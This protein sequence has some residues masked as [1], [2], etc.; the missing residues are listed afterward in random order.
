MEPVRFLGLSPLSWV[1]AIPA[2]TTLGILFTPSAAKNAVRRIALAGMTLTFGI[3]IWILV[4]AAGDVGLDASARVLP[5]LAQKVEWVRE[6]G[7]S[8]NVG[9]DGMGAAMVF[10]TSIV[11]FAGVLVSWSV[12]D[13]TKEFYLSLIALVTGVFGVFVSRDLFWFYFSY[14]LAVIPMYL[15]IGI[16]GS[17]NKE[18]ASM[19]LTLYLTTGAVCALVGLLM[20]YFRAWAFLKTP[21][22]SFDLDYILM[23]RDA[24][25]FDATWRGMDF[26]VFAFPFLL[27][28]FGAIAPMWPLHTWSPMGH[29]AAPSAASMLHAGVLMKLGSFAILRIAVPALPEG[30]VWWMPVVAVLCMFNILYG[31]L[32][33]IAQKDMKFI[34]GYSSSSHMGYVLLGI[35]SMTSLGING[36]IFLMF[37]HGVM[38]AL[39][40]ALIGFFYDQTHVRTIPDLGGMSHQIP[41]IGTAF[42][43]MSMASAGVPGFANF[44]S[45]VM[46]M[47]GAWQG[48]LKWQAVVAV[49]GI[50]PTGV[51]LLRAV[52]GAFFGPRNPRW[53][54]LRDAVTPFQRLPFLFLIS[55]LLLF[56]FWPRLLTDVIGESA[57][58]LAGL[59]ARAGGG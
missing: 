34:V 13:R 49:L 10:L 19:K 26:Q 25:A 33:A 28:G 36:A 6:L 45:E 52:K 5:R 11:I 56:G 44:A 39:A 41:F 2:L 29:A 32:V 7:I 15:L 51:Y 31:G 40:F 47:F 16:W 8:W 46:V 20:V 38:T 22:P 27:F 4:Q 17:T 48:G 23:A 54:G 37:A 57:D 59:L 21:Y 53:D 43:F 12:E 14:E 50:V 42:V 24:G 55:V 9:A 58:E 3:A 35:A 18:Y 30:A 1:V